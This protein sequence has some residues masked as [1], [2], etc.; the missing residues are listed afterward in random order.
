M[1]SIRAPVGEFLIETST[2]V[3]STLSV[4]LMR[5]RRRGL[6]AISSPQRSPVLIAVS[7]INRC[8][9]GRE[10]RMAT[11]SAGVRV[12]V[13][14]L[15]TLGSSVWAQGLKVTTRSRRARSITDP[16]MVWYLPTDAAARPFSV[17]EV[18]QRWI[19]EGRILPIGRGPKVG[20]KC[21]S[22]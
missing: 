21:L 5:S 4:R 20:M 7:T 13:C 11:Y 2:T 10:V 1:V 14:F 15:I 16:S 9:A 8:W 22:R 18:T 12:R 19:S 6:R 17:A 3:S